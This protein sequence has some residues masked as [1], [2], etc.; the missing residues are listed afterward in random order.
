MEEEV[1]QASQPIQNVETGV[2]VPIVVDLTGEDSEEDRESVSDQEGPANSAINEAITGEEPVTSED[3]SQA[4]PEDSNPSMDATPSTNSTIADP[5]TP[6]VAQSPVVEQ[7]SILGLQPT[8]SMTPE[9]TLVA[10]LA[11]RIVDWGDKNIELQRTPRQVDAELASQCSHPER[12][13]ETPHVPQSSPNTHRDQTS[14]AMTRV[15]RDSPRHAY[16]VHPIPR[17]QTVGPSP[18]RLPELRVQTNRQEK[19]TCQLPSIQNLLEGPQMGGLGNSQPARAIRSPM[20]PPSPYTPGS[21]IPNHLRPDEQQTHSTPT[22]MSPQ[23]T[24][25][26]TSFRSWNW[27]SCFTKPVAEQLQLASGSP[28]LASPRDF[29]DHMGRLQCPFCRIHVLQLDHFTQHLQ[30]PCRSILAG[31]VSLCMSAATR[32]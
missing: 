9:V 28:A 25:H 3:H 1:V 15:I 13:R 30:H 12:P 4:Q 17:P 6:V 14:H 27:L 19:P 7:E 31:Q 16:S 11:C 8:P 18:G 26:A 22:M 32:G 24:P 21:S 2:T 10:Q 23:L 29:M 5:P 20:M